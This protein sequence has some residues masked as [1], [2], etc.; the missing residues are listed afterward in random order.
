MATKLQ[1]GNTTCQAATPSEARPTILVFDSGVGG[2]SVYDEIRHLLPDLHYIY[3]FDNVAFPYGE[4]S[5]AFIVERV[6]EIVTAVQARY[7][8]A[9]AVIACNSASTVSLPA[10]REKFA[11]PVVGVVPAIKPAARLTA[12]GVVGLLATRGTVKRPYTHE[13]IARFANE[14]RIEMLG[15]AELVEIAEAKLHGEPV[16]L[17]ALRRVLRP[18]LRMPEP[19]DTVVLG[20]THFPLLAEELLQVLPEGTRLVDSG[21]AIARRTAW[22]LEHEAPDARSCDDNI[23]YCMALTPEVAQLMSVLQRYGFSKLE[24][25]PL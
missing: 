18:W 3:A 11:F 16:S 24:K 10:L 19:P 12:N 8:L 4:K 1:D 25:L 20:C 7:P 21:A 9:L 6:V 23:A 5:E 15:S 22:L 13:L 2:L 17:E 14:C